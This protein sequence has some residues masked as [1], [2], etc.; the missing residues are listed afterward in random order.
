[1]APAGRR[2]GSW[3]KLR[4]PESW[5]WLYPLDVSGMG[6]APGR[7]CR[8][9]H[10]AIA[11][12][13]TPLAC[14]TQN[15]GFLLGLSVVALGLGPPRPSEPDVRLKH[16]PAQMRFTAGAVRDGPSGGRERGS[17]LR[18]AVHHEVGVTALLEVRIEDRFAGR[19]TL[20]A[21]Y[22]RID[23]STDIRRNNC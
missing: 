8:L 6:S 5:T 19:A 4:W 15:T 12:V 17:Y 18:V 23:S 3:L 9:G 1:M 2:T 10:S 13:L 22:R 21:W 11:N 16:R 14:T 20:P 7:G